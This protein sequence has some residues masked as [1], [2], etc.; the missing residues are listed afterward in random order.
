MGAGIETHI[1][2]VFLKG[3]LGLTGTRTV[4]VIRRELLDEVDEEKGVHEVERGCEGG[5]RERSMCVPLLLYYRTCPV[6]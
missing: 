4:A 6:S 1:Y 5:L 3:A 2:V